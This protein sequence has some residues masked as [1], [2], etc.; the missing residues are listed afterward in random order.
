MADTVY[1]K[2]NNVAMFN[3]SS[4]TVVGTT[5]A[6]TF[7]SAVVDS[8]ILIPAAAAQLFYYAGMPIANGGP[9]LTTKLYGH[10]ETNTSSIV[11][12]GTAW[13]FIQVINVSGIVVFRVMMTNNGTYQCSYWNGSS[14][15][16]IGAAF[17]ISSTG[18]II[19]DFDFTPGTSGAFNLRLNNASIPV[20]SVSAFN[21]AVDNTAEIRVGNGSNATMYISQGVLANFDLRGA[22]LN[23]PRISGNGFYTDGTG[24][25]TDINTVVQNQGTGIGLTAV[26]QRKTFT[27]PSLTL[28][29]M[30]IHSVSVNFLGAVSGGVVNNAR[31]I[32]RRASTDSTGATYATPARGL[33]QRILPMYVDPSTS[34]SWTVANFNNTELGVQAQ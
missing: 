32:T 7:D 24:T 3:I 2:S 18:Q 16:N 27:K 12:T 14:Y 30:V 4:S 17:S 34:L 10:F 5:T 31:V 11:Y 28:T 19:F 1:F 6:G 33:E 21:A 20:V 26:S 15:I 22:K 25:Y 23:V 29:G 9:S 13:P 8:S